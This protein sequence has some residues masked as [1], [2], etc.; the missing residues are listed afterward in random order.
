MTRENRTR[1]VRSHCYCSMTM[2]GLLSTTVMM[3]SGMAHGTT[4]NDQL[5]PAVL[6]AIQ[7]TSMGDPH[8]EISRSEMRESAISTLLELVND[9]DP[10]V[11]A[12][13]IEGLMPAPARLEAVLGAAL[14]D[15]NL[16]VRSVAAITVGKL[17]LASLSE[18]LKPM[19]HDPSPFVRAAAIFG[20]RSCR[21][22]VNPTPLGTMVIADPSPRV[23]AQ[24]AYLLGELKDP[25]TDAMLRDAAKTDS[26]RASAAEKKV[27]EL[28][29]AEALVK[30]GD[31]DQLHTIRAAL[32]PSSPEE[33]DATVLAVQILGGLRDKG[34]IGQ[35]HNLAYQ[36]DQQGRPMPIEIRLAVAGALG[37]MGSDEFEK[38]AAHS[39]D[40]GSEPEQIQASWALGQIATP[41][42]V[43][44]LNGHLDAEDPRLRVAVASALLKAVER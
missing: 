3:C 12:N 14:A 39:L 1:C 22:D 19:V 15:P 37:A 8:D 9:D 42:A 11:R 6:H 26:P 2:L 24:A 17:K 31:E 18:A 44:I 16:G 38:L 30:L 32:Y 13:A 41:E 25:G 29:I 33:L 43:R 20:L 4:T 27:L 35:L 34:S 5:H 40:S 28:Q 10:Q 21:A 36:L 23:R 7:P